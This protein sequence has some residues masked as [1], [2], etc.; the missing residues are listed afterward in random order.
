MS[1]IKISPSFL[2]I[3]EYAKFRNFLD[4]V[5]QKGAHRIHVDFGDGKFIPEKSEHN[6]LWNL[7]DFIRLPQDLHLMV[8]EPYNWLGLIHKK[9]QVAGRKETYLIVHQEAEGYD[10]NIIGLIKTCGF[11]AGLALKPKTPLSVISSELYQELDLILVMTV[12]PG[13]SGQVII[14]DCLNKIAELDV[15][16]EENSYGFKIQVDGGIN[17]RTAQSAVN[18][19]AD[20][21]VSGNWIQEDPRR[22][23][24]LK[25]LKKEP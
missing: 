4:K 13:K 12:E 15:I 23:Q 5:E 10:E 7:R 14:G 25:N 2:G 19:G 22:I 20:I 21:L 18:A 16:R 24:W 17:G 1:G 8:H 11:L 9:R 3:K 6:L